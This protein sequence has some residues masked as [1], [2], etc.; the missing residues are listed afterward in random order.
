MKQQYEWVSGAAL[1]SGI[2][3]QKNRDVA[4]VRTRVDLERVRDAVLIHRVVQRSCARASPA[5]C[6]TIVHEI[7]QHAWEAEQALLRR[8]AESSRWRSVKVP[9]LVH[10]A[11]N[12]TDVDFVEDRQIV[13]TLRSRKRGTHPFDGGRQRVV[14]LAGTV[15]TKIKR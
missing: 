11:T 14:T 8:R 7:E 1:T 4:G 9:L 2:D 12:D 3:E 15:V 10:V 13:D 5:C 6:R